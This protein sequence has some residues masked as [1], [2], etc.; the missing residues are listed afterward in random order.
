MRSFKARNARAPRILHIGNIANNAYNNAKLLIE[1]GFD[2]DVICY[3]YYH[4]MGCPEWEDADFENTIADDF[5]PRWYKLNLNGFVRQPW[6]SQGPA[7]LCVAYLLAKNS[8]QLKYAAVLWR[9]LATFNHAKRFSWVE[10]FWAERDG[11]EQLRHFIAVL[12]YRFNVHIWCKWRRLMSLNANELILVSGRQLP[13][14]NRT[15]AAGAASIFTFLRDSMF[16]L[17]QYAWRGA[18]KMDGQRVV[19]T[20]TDDGKGPG[21]LNTLIAKWTDCFPQNC[22][23]PSYAEMAAHPA[24]T[25]NW[26][27]LL[28]SYDIVIGY[29]TDPIYPMLAGVPY[30]AFEHGTL[31]HIPYQDDYQGRITAASYHEATHVFVTNFDCVAS[32]E[33]LVGNRYTFINHPF[34]DD[35]GQNITGGLEQRTRLQLKLDADLIFFFPTRQDWVDGTGYA[36]KA[37]DVFFRAMATLRAT[38]VR[39]GAVCCIWGKNVTQSKALINSLS[40]D[41]HVEWTSPLPV[42]P[43]ERM[44]IAADIVVDQFKLGAFGGV[45]F[46]AM[47]VGAPILTYLNEALLKAQYPVL[48]PVINCRTE[49]DIVE[50]ISELRSD[51][52]KLKALGQQSKAWIST[53]HA[54]KDTVNLQVAQFQKLLGNRT[55]SNFQEKA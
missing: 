41:A 20:A 30:F 51:A 4:I 3:D 47:A 53:H 48:P 15:F 11:A 18:R 13:W 27:R 22:A 8:G 49:Q 33:R 26:T 7:G 46:K 34:D 14:L 35:H 50:Q 23:P 2:C 12:R 28:N 6:F 29:S 10:E 9:V 54:K 55:D 21:L 19:V 44:C 45:V 37:N 5:H 52:L 38:G 17:V 43:F 42:I 16:F 39:V 24:T 40:L 25:D 1:A 31:R 36:D 32:A